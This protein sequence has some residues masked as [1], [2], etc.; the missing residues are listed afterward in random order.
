MIMDTFDIKPSREV[1]DIKIAI[2]E[3]ILDGDIAN[4]YDAAFEFMITKG[5]E[6]GLMPNKNILR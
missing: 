6:L 4:N 3:A 5:K 2:R 1:G